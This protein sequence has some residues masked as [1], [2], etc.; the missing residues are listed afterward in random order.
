LLTRTYVDDNARLRWCPAP[1]CEYAIECQ[2]PQAALKTV[3]PTVQCQC[4][5]MFCYGCGLEDHMPCICVL[6]RMWLRKCED[7]SETSNWIHVNTKECTKCNSTIE[8]NGGCNHMTCRKCQNEF[9][10]VCLGPWSEHGTSW[11][12]CNRYDEA[13]SKSARD[14]Q[15]RS[16]QQLE[17]YLHYYNRYANHDQS[18]HLDKELHSRTEKKMEEMQQTSD[19]SWIE[20][21]FLRTAVD[22]LVQ[23]RMTLKWTYAFAYYLARNNETELFEDNQRDLELA[24]EQLSEM[25]EQPIDPNTIKDLKQN[26]LDKSAYVAK[27]REVLIHDVA[28]GLANDRWKYNVEI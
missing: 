4:G 16:R 8:K 22:K 12:S 1:G 7:D 17:R 10:W 24:V 28:L 5:Y 26:V 3:V 11:Y 14:S 27:R 2:V 13:S 9:C 25:L 20:V 21:Q 15:A 6:V 18:A 23:C 19:L